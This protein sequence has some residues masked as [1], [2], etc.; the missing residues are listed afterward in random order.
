MAGDANAGP[1]R[2]RRREHSQRLCKRFCRASPFS[3]TADADVYDRQG[4]SEISL[5]DLLGAAR[6]ARA[7]CCPPTAK[8]TTPATRG[9]NRSDDP[10]NASRPPSFAVREWLGPRFANGSSTLRGMCWRPAASLFRLSE[11]VSEGKRT[12][13][14]AVLLPW[15]L[16][17]ILLG[18]TAAFGYRAYTDAP[19][20]GAGPDRRLDLK[21]AAAAGAASRRRWLRRAR[22]C[23]RRRAISFRCIRFRSAPRCGYVDIGGRPAEE[24]MLQGRHPLARIED[25]NYRADFEHAK[26]ALASAN[27]ATNNR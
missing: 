24:G 27:G 21:D 22:W 14:A 25:V 15:G 16:C 4:M 17:L 2:R 20:R 11:R 8:F 13:F 10:P 26:Y 3:G 18:V 1:A 7:G 6:R 5:L 9:W 19:L 23:W 12:S